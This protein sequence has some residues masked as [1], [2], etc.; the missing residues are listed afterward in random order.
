M[1]LF[2]YFTYDCVNS[3]EMMDIES[4]KKKMD[5]SDLALITGE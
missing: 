3:L 4:M 5:V 2:V 1:H